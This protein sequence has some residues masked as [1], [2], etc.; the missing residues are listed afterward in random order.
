MLSAPSESFV[1]SRSCT[2]SLLTRQTSDMSKLEQALVA[3]VEVYEDYAKQD[4]RKNL[5][6]KKELAQLLEAQLSSPEF[7]G[8]VDPECIQ[9]AMSKLDKDSDGEVKFGEF[10]QM[11][12]I[13]AR[14]LFSA[15]RGKGKKKKEDD[16]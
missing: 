4:E 10:A 7:K 8:K 9:Q 6:S 5:L 16:E 2:L 14:G 15:R 11:M 13:L 12:A 3:I 1:H